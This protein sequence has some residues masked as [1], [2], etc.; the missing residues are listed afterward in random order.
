MECSECASGWLTPAPIPE[1]LGQC[2]VGSYYTHERPEAATLGQSGPIIL[3]RRLALSARR[4]YKQLRPAIPF[5]SALGAIVARIPPV[6]SRACF[7]HSDLLPN[8]KSGGR[9]LEI[10][11]GG[12]RFLSIMQLLGWQVSGIEPDPAAAAV[13]R[14]LVGCEIHAGTI[15]DAPFEA[16]RFDAIVSS[17]V[18]EHVYDPVSFVQRAGGLLAPGGVMTVLTPNFGSVGHKLFGTDWY[19]LDPPRHM[20][21]F[22]AKSLRKV[23]VSAGVFREVRAKTITRASGNAIERRRAVRATGNFLGN[24]GNGARVSDL[25]FR[26]LEA[27]GNRLFDWGEEIQ[28]VAVK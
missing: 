2:Y 18:I 10:G 6:W 25:L 9:L 14:D 11:C 26:S 12:G 24:A 22:T 8:F 28:C 7:G 5:S 4:G 17:H 20:C 21:L 23:F 13:A 1:D 3:L 19:C 16:G 15:E 27:A